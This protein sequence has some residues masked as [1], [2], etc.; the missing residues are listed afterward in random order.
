MPLEIQMSKEHAT[1]LLGQKK[2]A[3]EWP[4]SKPTLS[5]IKSP[6]LSSRVPGGKHGENM[7]QTER[8][9]LNPQP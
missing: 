4:D 3:T 2:Q 5:R 8:R 6:L 1:T 7:Q 9:N